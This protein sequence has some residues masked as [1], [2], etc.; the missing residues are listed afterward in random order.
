M[1]TPDEGCL[2]RQLV[3]FAHKAAGRVSFLRALYYPAH[4]WYFSRR[5]IAT[6]LQR[7]EFDQIRFYREQTVN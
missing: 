6:G 5:A 3:R 2:A 4:R 1:E 7:V